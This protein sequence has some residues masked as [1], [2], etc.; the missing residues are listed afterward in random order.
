[1]NKYIAAIIESEYKQYGLYDVK[2]KKSTTVGSNL[3]VYL[4]VVHRRYEKNS[5]GYCKRVFYDYLLEEDIKKFLFYYFYDT[6]RKNFDKSELMS[7]DN[8]I[9]IGTIELKRYMKDG[10]LT[11]WC[12]MLFD[13][14]SKFSTNFKKNIIKRIDEIGFTKTLKEFEYIKGLKISRA[15][16]YN[17]IKRK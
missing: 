16:I 17:I 11:R 5:H 8:I 10:H 9:V 14:K 12:P 2:F 13:S 3:C 1:M 15:S 6:K 4:D 7:E